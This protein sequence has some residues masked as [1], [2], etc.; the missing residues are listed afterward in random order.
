MRRPV[1]TTKE[2]AHGGTMGSP[3]LRGDALVEDCLQSICRDHVVSFDDPATT[4]Y[5]RS[6]RLARE[7]L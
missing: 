5:E 7:A 4:P 1:V 6:R 2:R 3:T